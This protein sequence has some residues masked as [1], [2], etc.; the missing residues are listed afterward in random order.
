MGKWMG[1][2]GRFNNGQVQEKGYYRCSQGDCRCFDEKEP[3]GI[4]IGINLAAPIARVGSIA[5]SGM[6]YFLGNSVVYEDLNPSFI[7]LL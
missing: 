2:S 7:F 5:S 6:S 4:S 3:G 1:W